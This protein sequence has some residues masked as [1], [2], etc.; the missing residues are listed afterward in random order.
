MRSFEYLLLPVMASR[1]RAA[2]ASLIAATASSTLSL[3]SH[4]AFGEQVAILDRTVEHI[5]YVLI[6]QNSEHPRHCPG[7]GCVQLQDPS[8]RDLCVAE[9]GNKYSRN[10]EIGGVPAASG[11]LVGSVGPDEGRCSTVMS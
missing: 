6:G 9:P 7:S 2:V 1:A 5:G 3:G 8:M 10:G 4:H 11:Y